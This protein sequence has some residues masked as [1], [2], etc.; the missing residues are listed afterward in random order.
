VL[1]NTPGD[2]TYGQAD[3]TL[4]GSTVG[5][6]R[7]SLVIDATN[8]DEATFVETSGLLQPDKPR[9]RPGATPGR[10]RSVYE[11]ATTGRYNYITIRRRLI[12]VLSNRYERSNRQTIHR[13]DRLQVRHDPPRRT[14][15]T[16]PSASRA[17]RK[18][19]TDRGDRRV[20]AIGKGFFVKS[21]ARDANWPES[22][23]MG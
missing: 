10:G 21:I 6:V 18:V 4:V 16:P 12:V 11:A 22:R 7:G 20:V 3:V 17:P 5:N 13:R 19:L 15:H 9:A 23:V 14:T 8:P 1:Y 2:T